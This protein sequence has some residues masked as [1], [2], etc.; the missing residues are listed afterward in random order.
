[1][2]SPFLSAIFNDN[3]GGANISNFRSAD[4]SPYSPVTPAVRTFHLIETPSSYP[5]VDSK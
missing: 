3:D 1:M 2:Y 4:Q 5:E